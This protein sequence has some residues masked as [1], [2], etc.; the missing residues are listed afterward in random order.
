MAAPNLKK[1]LVAI[2]TYKN[3][4]IKIPKKLTWSCQHGFMEV[5]LA[6]QLLALPLLSFL[7]LINAMWLPQ[8]LTIVSPENIAH[9]TKV[10][11]IDMVYLLQHAQ[12]HNLDACEQNCPDK[13]QQ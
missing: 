4:K 6:F 10:N 2:K 11:K 5:W 12:Y 8:H 9:L 3:S 1:A 7:E 13:L